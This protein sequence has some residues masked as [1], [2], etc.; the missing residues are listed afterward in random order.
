MPK[1]IVMP[2]LGLTMEEATLLRWVCQEGDSF[3]EGDVIFEIETD[4]VTSDVEAPFS[5]T[6]AKILVPEG[7][8]VPVATPVAE[9]NEG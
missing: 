3:K 7:E 2:R 4:K 8:T 9:A 1:Q 5:G 6:L